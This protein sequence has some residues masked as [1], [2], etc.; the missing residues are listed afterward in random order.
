MKEYDD[1]GHWFK[2]PEGLDDIMAFLG[3]VT[4]RG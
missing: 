4:Q 2:D 3:Q 1:C